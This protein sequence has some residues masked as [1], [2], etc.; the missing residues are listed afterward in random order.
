VNISPLRSL[1]NE[2]MALRK[3]FEL[4]NRDRQEFRVRL[5][6]PQPHPQQTAAPA[7]KPPSAPSRPSHARKTGDGCLSSSE[8][9][10]FSARGGGKVSCARIWMA[11]FI[12]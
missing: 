10:Q 3:G 4:L 9:G 1:G 12:E 6:L 7:D 5:S 11:V 8:G 2:W